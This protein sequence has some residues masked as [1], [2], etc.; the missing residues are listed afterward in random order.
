MLLSIVAMAIKEHHR[1][2]NSY[3]INTI[4]QKYTPLLFDGIMDDVFLHLW[5]FKTIIADICPL[6]MFWQMLH[7]QVSLSTGLHY[8]HWKYIWAALFLACLC[9][10]CSSKANTEHITEQKKNGHTHKHT[11]EVVLWKPQ[12]WIKTSCGVTI[13]HHHCALD[14]QSEGRR[15]NMFQ[16]IRGPETH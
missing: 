10:G 6:Y 14:V 5:A 9:L 3:V 4:I 16:T 7:V 13:T 15:R 12:R 1:K 8:V 2:I 11:E